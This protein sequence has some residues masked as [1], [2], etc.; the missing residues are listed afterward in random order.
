MKANTFGNTKHYNS[1]QDY[2]SRLD[3]AVNTTV[4]TQVILIDT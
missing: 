1:L 2:F 3:L 4:P